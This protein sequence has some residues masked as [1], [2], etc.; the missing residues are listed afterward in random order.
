MLKYEEAKR[1]R[2]DYISLD[3]QNRSIAWKK[4]FN[5]EVHLKGAFIDADGEE[6]EVFN[7]TYSQLPERLQ[8][9]LRDT[10]VILAVAEGC[11]Y[12]E[13]HEIFVN[14][15]SGDALNAQEIRNAINTPISD[16]VRRLSERDYYISCISN[17]SGFDPSKFARSY[18][19]EYIAKAYMA[20][21]KIDDRSFNTAK[22]DLDLFYLIGKGKRV[23]NVPEYSKM[24]QIRFI[25]IL[26]KQCKLLKNQTKIP[27]K[28]GGWVF[29]LLKSFW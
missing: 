3:G 13:L 10:E 2:K 6:V 11:L 14:I 20:T 29:T 12:D 21:L 4:L 1:L 16:F 23:Q 18:D 22:K 7:T 27:Q 28:L 25:N 15:N 8:D 26:E 19:A 24:N 9:A 17:V 5:D